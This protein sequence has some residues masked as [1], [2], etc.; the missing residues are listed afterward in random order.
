MLRAKKRWRNP[1]NL[2]EWRKIT[3]TVNGQ[4]YFVID[5]AT[6]LKYGPADLN[7]LNQWILEGR[8]L[9][10]TMLED[11]TSGAQLRADRVPGVYF[12]ESAASAQVGAVPAMSPLAPTMPGAQP[13]WRG[14][15]LGV[16]FEFLI[17]SFALAKK[18][19][20]QWVPVVVILVVANLIGNLPNSMQS[21][22]RLV[23]ATDSLEAALGIG[24]IFSMLWSLLVI[25]VLNVGSLC[26]AL[27]IV[28][29][30]SPDVGRVF[31]PFKKWL[32]VVVSHTVYIIMVT[33]GMFFCV[34]PGFYLLGRLSYWPV[35]VA[36]QNSSIMDAYSLV[37]DRQGRFAWA[38]AGLLIVSYIL[39]ALGALACLVG[40]FF[41]V[42]VACMTLASQYRTL[43]PEYAPSTP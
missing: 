25:Q 21:G 2:L 27:D 41:T 24:S 26:F 3:V 20:S 17:D 18:T 10:S 32:A 19:W 16:H 43:Y 29:G 33:V 15:P 36:E 31:S 35:T 22:W 38:M 13:G 42:P 40:L 7:T 34:A 30:K 4:T 28:D 14:Y 11:A 6:G 1:A 12:A 23:P 9:P 39:A 37:W 8:V 5:A